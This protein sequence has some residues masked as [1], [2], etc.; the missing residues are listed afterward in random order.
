M[1]KITKGHIITQNLDG[2]D[3]LDCLYRISLKALIYNDAG[4]I[5][6]VK[7]ID[8]TY[9]DLPGGGMDFGETIESSLKRELYE[10]VG[11]KGDL[12]YQLFDVSDEMYI[13]R[14]DANQIC[15]YFRV[16]PE[17]FDFIPSEEGDEVM[18][19]DPEE[20]LLQKSEVDAPA[21]AH[22]AH[23]KWQELHS[24]IVR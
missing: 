21:R 15:F 23:V 16:W 1:T 24:E 8:R 13:E 3:H 12:R 22:A 18:F 2:T 19:V 20:L 11:Y 17:N 5:L 6:V 10:E 14:I 4:Q 7:E 9:W